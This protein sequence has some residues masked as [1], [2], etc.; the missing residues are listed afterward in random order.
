MLDRK[1]PGKIT[2][3][4]YNSNIIIAIPDR[5]DHFE[6]SIWRSQLHNN[7]LKQE[8]DTLSALTGIVNDL[9]L[10]LRIWSKE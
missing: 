2:V 5:T 10:N 7:S 6:T 9:N 8:Y 1:F 4:F 3:S